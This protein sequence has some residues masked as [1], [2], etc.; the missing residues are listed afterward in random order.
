MRIKIK[1]NGQWVSQEVGASSI[2]IDK[3]LSKE[4]FAA[5]AS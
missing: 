3:T 4:G 2:S 5:D 1:Q